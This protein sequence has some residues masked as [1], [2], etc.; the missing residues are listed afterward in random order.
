MTWFPAIFTF[1]TIRGALDHH[2]HALYRIAHQGW[3]A[4]RAAYLPTEGNRANICKFPKQ[5][6]HW[7]GSGGLTYGLRRV[8]GQ[9][10]RLRDALSYCYLPHSVTRTFAPLRPNGRS[11]AQTSIFAIEN[12][13]FLVSC[14]RARRQETGA[15][16]QGKY[17]SHSSPIVFFSISAL[18]HQCTKAW[19]IPKPF[20]S[21]WFFSV[22][23]L[24]C[25]RAR[26]QKKYESHSF[27]VFVQ[28]FCFPGPGTLD[29]GIWTLGSGLWILDFGLCI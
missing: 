27:P 23:L 4:A 10:P 11:R 13:H 18:L 1:V 29:F 3:M 15:R 22:F 8:A 14:I 2:W 24:S 16:R 19:I 20:I 6:L 7:R 12:Q 5:C 9:L 28:Y 25:I 17:E 21:Y 26:R